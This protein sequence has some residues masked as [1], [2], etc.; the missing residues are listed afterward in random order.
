MSRL[1]SGR[2]WWLVEVIFFLQSF[3]CLVRTG[4]GVTA[5]VAVLTG[6]VMVHVF[7]VV[8]FLWHGDERDT[9]IDRLYGD[10][11]VESIPL[12]KTLISAITYS[13]KS[14]KYILIIL[15]IA[16]VVLSFVTKK[17]SDP[18]PV[19]DNSAAGEAM[20][21]GGTHYCYEWGTNA[22]DRASVEIFVAPG[23]DSSGSVAWVPAEKDSKRGAFEGVAYATDEEGIKRLMKGWWKTSG[24]GMT[25]T[26]ELYIRFDEK[27]AA[28]GFGEMKDRGDGTYVYA[29]TATLSYVPSLLRVDCANEAAL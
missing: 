12:S 8:S 9:G 29:N 2:Y 19:I 5:S 10:E 22:G 24:E 20:L 16:I 25:A 26:E 21:E 18:Q 14:S 27:M 7:F 6:H 23:G 3:Y 4:V 1:Q 15:I 28:V 11:S 17:K 13:M